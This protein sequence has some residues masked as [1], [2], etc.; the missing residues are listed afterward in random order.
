[1][2][3]FVFTIIT[4]LFFAIFTGALIASSVRSIVEGVYVVDQIK[5]KKMFKR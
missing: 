2:I 1:M 3:H 4:H 5:K